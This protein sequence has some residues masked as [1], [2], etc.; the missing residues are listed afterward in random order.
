MQ[1][2]FN[3]ALR[4]SQSLCAWKDAPAVTGYNSYGMFRDTAGAGPS[5][6]WRNQEFYPDAEECRV[7][8]PSLSNEEN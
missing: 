1:L 6:H 7:I 2:M 5:A 4:F 3:K 8:R